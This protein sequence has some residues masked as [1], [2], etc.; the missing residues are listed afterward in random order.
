MTGT[1]SLVARFAEVSEDALLASV[2]ASVDS[3]KEQ[4]LQVHRKVVKSVHAQGRL[5]E[6]IGKDPGKFSIRKMATG[7]IDDFHKGLQDRIGIIASLIAF[8]L[9][10]TSQRARE[11]ANIFF[12]PFSIFQAHPIWNF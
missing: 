9:H 5:Q 10:I 4:L 3:L 1:N 2:D 6:T 8:C 7:S 12:K 11:R